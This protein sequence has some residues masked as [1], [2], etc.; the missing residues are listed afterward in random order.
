MSLSL[1]EAEHV[2]NGVWHG[3]LQ[4]KTITNKELLLG[5]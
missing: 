2:K 4:S 1:G 3:A 5:M